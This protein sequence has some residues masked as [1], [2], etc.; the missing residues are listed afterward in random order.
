MK[1]CLKERLR[2]CGALQYGSFTL[3]SG[4]ESSYYVDIK[5]A[6]TDPKV[7]FKS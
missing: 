4:A 6:S 1:M 5:R 7:F 3:A 2:E